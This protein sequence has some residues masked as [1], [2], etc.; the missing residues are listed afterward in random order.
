MRKLGIPPESLQP[1][2]YAGPRFALIPCT[3]AK[4]RPTV[5]DRDYSL[6]TN[7]RVDFNPSTGD[8]GE[9]WQLV[10]FEGNG[11]AT[12]VRL[13][14]T[15]GT[16]AVITVTPDDFTSPGVSPI[17]PSGTGNMTIIGGVVANHS[18]PIETH[19]RALNTFSIEAQV[20]K[21]VTGAPGT[22]LDAGVVSFDDTA[23]AVDADGYV[24]FLAGV[25]PAFTTFT[26][27]AV[28]GP[29]VQPVVP[30]SGNVVISG[31]AVAAHSVPVE[32]HS[33]A[34]S[35]YNV[36]VQVASATTG[37]PSSK[38]KAGIA[39]FDDSSFAVDADG[40]VTLTSS[41][42]K[43]SSINVDANTAPG[44]DPVVPTV[45]GAITVSGAAVAAHSVP[46]E[47]RSR[48]A[49]EYNIEVQLATTEAASGAGSAEKGIASFSDDDFTVTDGFVALKNP[50]GG[51]DGASNLGIKYS[52]G[53]F[54]ICAKDGTDLSATN[55][56]YVTIPLV[57][58]PG[59][60]KTITI[61]DNHQ[62][63]DS[64]GTSTVAGMYWGTVSSVGWSSD[65]P[66]FI[67]AV[68]K[69]DDSDVAFAISRSPANEIS[70]ASS[71]IGVR[72]AVVTTNENTFF[73]LD[74]ATGPTSPTVGDYDTNP[75]VLIGSF[76]MRKV[77]SAA[78][79]WTVQALDDKDGIGR[80]NFG[81][82][83]T[84]PTGVN[85]SASGKYFQATTGT[86]PAWSGTAVLYT[87]SKNGMV[88][89][90]HEHN[91]SS[92]AGAGAG[93]LGATIPVSNSIGNDAFY[94]WAILGTTR[95][96]IAGTINA[97]TTFVT[98]YAQSGTSSNWLNS[99]VSTATAFSMN[100]SYKGFTNV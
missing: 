33:R 12:W 5:L 76:R 32:I 11:D 68:M 98:A 4:R 99:T 57:A 86:P 90:V 50:G 45:G 97:G 69:D 8:E 91:T 37:T 73:L 31:A 93:V 42:L 96:I 34:A 77:A 58:T 72:G 51:S 62:F 1:N 30:S 65:M 82:F 40:Y 21:A 41:G 15:S 38:A 100:I 95:Y 89:V 81:T 54:S 36:E 85:G 52:A 88:Y 94:A 18:A 23:F 44:T 63:V 26:V 49:N 20:G 80:F 7:W 60:Y 24:T 71:N 16:G 53:T 46:I 79:D 56:G 6:L 13:E 47:I 19:T 10:K 2:R 55:P 3:E 75:T 35:E 29:G 70:Y 22:M 27:D 28:T 64:T 78:N 48:A 59:L 87:V 17:D 43:V 61:T 25:G 66:F 83:W 67:Y 39:Q 84:M 74:K 9:V 92:V 14:G